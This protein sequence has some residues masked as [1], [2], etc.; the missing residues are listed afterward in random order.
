MIWDQVLEIELLHHQDIVTYA[1]RILFVHPEKKNQK[2]KQKEKKR[3]LQTKFR[4]KG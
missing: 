4:E 2:K 1:I 3:K